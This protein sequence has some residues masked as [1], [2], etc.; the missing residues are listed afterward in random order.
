MESSARDKGER[1]ALQQ[2]VVWKSHP[3]P[4]DISGALAL[5][6]SHVRPM[7]FII[8]LGP[9]LKYVHLTAPCCYLRAVV[10]LCRV[11]SWFEDTKEGDLRVGGVHT[12]LVSEH[13]CR[14]CH[15]LRRRRL[16]WLEMA[17]PIA[18]H[19][20]TR[21]GKS[22]HSLSNARPH[23]VLESPTSARTTSS[24]R[25]AKPILSFQRRLGKTSANSSRATGTPALARS[26]RCTSWHIPL[27]VF[28]SHPHIRP[29]THTGSNPTTLCHCPNSCKHP[30][31]E[32]SHSSCS[33]D[34]FPGQISVPNMALHTPNS[35]ETSRTYQFMTRINTAYALQLSTYHDLFLW[36]TE[37]IDKFWSAVWDETGIIGVKG[38]HIV[39]TDAQP[40][41]N[42]PWF[43]HAQ[44]N[45][46]EN[47]LRCR[48]SHKTALVQASM[49][50]FMVRCTFVRAAS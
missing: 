24:V 22:E 32:L 1:W 10:T 8:R 45:Y 43:S 26:T 33:S 18:V 20:V 49:F 40:P 14:M 11:C 47:M 16:I 39:N 34:S 41:E 21:P 30:A 17:K 25:P 2:K 35:P 12:S 7:R 37:N 46:A 3:Q 13:S 23:P 4:L 9:L 44:L 36:S 6:A 38:D 42:P 28:S 29:R 48:G 27:P 5:S 50:S 15:F 31:P 19:W